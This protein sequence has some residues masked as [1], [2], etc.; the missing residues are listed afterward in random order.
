MKLADIRKEYSQHQLDEHTVAPDPY[1]Q[2]NLWMDE[3]LKSG[4]PEPTAM[5]LST[6][7]AEGWPS[8]RMV[9]LK[10]VD[11][12]FHFFTNYESRKGHEID[13]TGRTSLCFWWAELER[14]VRIEGVA[15]RLTEAESAAYYHS[16]PLPARLGAWA[17]PQ[18]KVL[19][20]RTELEGLLDKTTKAMADAGNPELPPFWG[21]YRVVP[22]YLEFW[23]GRPSRLHDRIRY[24]LDGQHWIR[25]RLA[26]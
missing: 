11:H 18:S 15:E 8:S 25:E 4:V 21:G 22:H 13:A 5:C 17:S 1:V 14:Q 24:R 12:G 19:R 3:A 20:D 7:S 2:F 9:L 6:V 10:G 23:Q 16:R 26:P